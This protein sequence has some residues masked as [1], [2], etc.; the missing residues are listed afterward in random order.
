MPKIKHK[1]FKVAKKRKKKN[2]YTCIS[3]MEQSKEVVIEV[4]NEHGAKNDNVKKFP[5]YE[6]QFR[7]NVGLH[8]FSEN[9]AI[10]EVWYGHFVT[11]TSNKEV[12]DSYQV[13]E[14]YATLPT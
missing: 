1:P 7:M 5:V 14:L 10:P 6:L 12:A 8:R 4:P 3:K 11:H 9:D 13:G 2:M